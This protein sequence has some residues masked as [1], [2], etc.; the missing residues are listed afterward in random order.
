M[1]RST[2]I[3][4]RRAS[5][6]IDGSYEEAIKAGLVRARLGPREFIY[7]LFEQEF[8]PQV[9][10]TG[11]YREGAP[12][13]IFGLTHDQLVWEPEY[14]NDPNSLRTC[15]KVCG[16]KPAIAVYD[17]DQLEKVYNGLSG[18]EYSFKNPQEKTK[19]LKGIVKLIME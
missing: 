16:E 13:T 10:E 11:S 1:V 18:F 5:D 3:D 9:K 17:L 19:A 7:S 6:Y 4:L 2:S 8:I 12:D 14:P 15:T